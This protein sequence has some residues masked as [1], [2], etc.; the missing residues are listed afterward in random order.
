[1]SWKIRTRLVVEQSST[2]TEIQTRIKEQR[3]KD[4]IAIVMTNIIEPAIA[5]TR[6]TIEEIGMEET[7]E[8]W[9]IENKLEEETDIETKLYA[10]ITLKINADLKNTVGLATTKKI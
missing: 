5:D 9:T 8:V 4:R 10:D 7:I 1:M 3:I 2:K 6:K